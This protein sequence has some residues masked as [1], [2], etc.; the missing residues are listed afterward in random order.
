MRI[1][2]IRVI[3]NPAAKGE[4][5]ARLIEQIKGLADGLDVRISAAPGDPSVL[6]RQAI[7]EG[8]KVIVAAGGDGTINQVVNGLAGHDDVTLG[9]LPVGTMNVF[10]AELG[11]PMQLDRAWKSIL[12]GNTREV[13][14]A[15]AGERYFVQLAGVGLDA[16]VVQ[17]TDLE[18]RKNFGPLSYLVSIAQIANR[19]PPVLRVES[20]GRGASEGSFVLIGNGRFY[21]GPFVIFKSAKPDD[22]LLDILVFKKLSFIDLI[23]YLQ[24]VIFGTHV[25]MSDVDYFQ[26]ASVKITSE[27]PDVPVEVDGEMAGALPLEVTLADSRLRVIV[28]KG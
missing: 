20:P 22:G 16:Q 23:R 9:I 11:L 7:G 17:E 28:P 10:A 24:G 21:G 8:V 19:K 15:K 27:T 26:A 18:F 3:L 4:K 5:A 14:L 6:A 12:A 13:D 2:Q 25:Q 1:D